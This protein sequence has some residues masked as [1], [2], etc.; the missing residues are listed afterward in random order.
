M[1]SKVGNLFN[2]QFDEDYFIQGMV[3][4]TEDKNRNI[5]K[6]DNGS[7]FCI[8]ASFY[9]GVTITEYYIRDTK[10]EVVKHIRLINKL[11]SLLKLAAYREE[12]RTIPELKPLDLIICGNHKLL[13]KDPKIYE[14]IG[15]RYS[16]CA[17]YGYFNV[18]PN[19]TLV[20]ESE[21]K[22]IGELFSRFY[23]RTCELYRDNYCTS[24]RIRP[25]RF[26]VESEF[27][28]KSRRV[29]M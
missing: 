28:S 26:V 21:E 10:L 19:C 27:D 23:S 1:H 6:L 13:V 9:L 11:K 3:I 12:L 7:L 25:V 2:F 22:I 18:V 5:F 14:L 24:R 20:V 8:N 17:G 16:S 29:L 4:N 15:F